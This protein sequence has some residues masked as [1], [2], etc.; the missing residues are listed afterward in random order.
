MWAV[1]VSASPRLVHVCTWRRLTY[2][3]LTFEQN[4]RHYIHIS[5]LLTDFHIGRGRGWWSYKWWGWVFKGTSR[6]FQ[7]CLWW[8]KPD[9]LQGRSG[10]SQAEWCGDRT[11]CFWGNLWTFPAVFVETKPGYF[12]WEV[13]LSLAVFVV[14]ELGVFQEKLGTFPTM[15]VVK[16]FKYFSRAV[17]PISSSV[18]G[19][20]T[21]YF[22]RRFWDIS[23]C[24]CGDQTYW[25]S[26]Q[27]PAV[28]V[29]TELATF[30]ETS[31]HFQLFLWCSNLD[32]FSCVESSTAVWIMLFSKTITKCC[33]CQNLTRAYKIHKHFK[34]ILI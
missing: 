17:G 19:D 14:T 25:K 5:C 11:R 3:I 22:L 6:H 23:S 15:F 16:E 29:G 7:T 32:I 8:S 20:R 30:Q 31:E 18:C 27:C 13:R 9:I 4:V 10:Q 28:L 26:G 34:Y 24:V 33:V 2:V 12:L 1:S 21:G